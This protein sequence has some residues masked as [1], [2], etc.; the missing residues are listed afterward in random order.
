MGLEAL[1]PFLVAVAVVLVAPGPTLALVLSTGVTHGFSAALFT[2]LGVSTALCLSSMAAALGVSALIVADP[3]VLGLVRACGIAYLLSL[4]YRERRMPG[5]IATSGP[6][7]SRLHFQRGFLVDALNPAGI[8]FLVSFLPQF[9][10][11]GAGN[12]TRQ[13]LVLAV[14]YTSCD[15]AF[16]V[17][18]AYLSSSAQTWLPLGWRALELR[19]YLMMATYMGLSVYLLVLV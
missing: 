12:V 16:N 19:R 15:L 1:I 6:S 18:L 13:L 11:P 10:D 2:G 9:V 8:L 4:A 5:P 3:A 7:S 17:M 14:L